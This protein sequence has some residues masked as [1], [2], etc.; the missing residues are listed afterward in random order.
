M[1]GSTLGVDLRHVRLER[2]EVLRHAASLRTALAS[3][4]ASER[5]G[6]LRVPARGELLREIRSYCRSAPGDARDVVQ[7]GIG[8]SS[9]G[10][11]A[12]CAAL[13]PARHNEVAGRGERRFHFL[14]NV[15]PESVGALLDRLDPRRTIVH[16]VSKSGGTLETAAQLHALLEAFRVRGRSFSPSRQFVVT[17]GPGGALREWAEEGEVPILTFPE[18]VAGRFSV[19]TASGLLVPA[20][21]GVPVARILSGARAM[22][23]R[24]REDALVG[25]AGRF[26]ALLYE[27]DQIHARPIHVDFI[28]AD[29]LRWLGGWFAQLWAES[30]G[31]AGSGPTPVVARGTTDQHSQLQLYTEGP[32]DK[33]YTVVR[34][35]RF[36]GR[37]KI[38]RSA[39]APLSGAPLARVFAA[40][41]QGTV[42][43]LVE[44]GRPVAQLQLPRITPQL[45]GELLALRQLQTA[46]AGSLYRVNPFDQPGVEAGK[47]AAL[48]ILSS[49]SPAG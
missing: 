1:A 48:R 33:V 45:L 29:A 34:V 26:A 38:G 46:L 2:H 23:A 10:A 12:I 9:L 5:G 30:L 35:E 28:Y 40:E 19:L 20:L 31:K 49:G 43:S 6:F 11:Q 13:L 8:G 7:L 41:A 25:P 44:L 42:E 14:D 17:T 3:L 39:P 15:D 47:Q 24:C 27:H 21:C 22:E 4:D 16:V 18:D 32:D 37:V 36:R